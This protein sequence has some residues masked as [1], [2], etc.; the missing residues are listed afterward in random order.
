M[1][2]LPEALR[3]L[4]EAE[5]HD[6]RAREEQERARAKRERALQILGS[7][8]GQGSGDAAPATSATSE[9]A[10]SHESAVSAAAASAGAATLEEEEGRENGTDDAKAKKREAQRR[11]VAKHKELL[12]GLTADVDALSRGLADDP[13]VSSGRPALPVQQDVPK[14]TEKSERAKLVRRAERAHQKALVEWHQ[15]EKHRLQLLRSRREGVADGVFMLDSL[16]AAP[17]EDDTDT[18]DV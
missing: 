3:L 18:D 7:Q 6:V 2:F 11:F 5:V 8:P 17:S 1:S 12:G 13:G 15:K 10:G 14:S 9:K 16:P 4:R